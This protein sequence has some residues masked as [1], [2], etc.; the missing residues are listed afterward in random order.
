MNFRTLILMGGAGIALHGCT[1]L[2]SFS[3]NSAENFASP[4][5]MIV[6][7]NMN[8]ANGRAKE[9]VYYWGA[10]Q[11]NKEVQSLYPRKHLNSYC[12]TKGG[13][14]SLL[15][16]SSMNLVKNQWDKKQL[17]SYSSVKQG[18]GAYKCMQSDGQSWIVSIEPVTERKLDD[19]S[20]ARMVA[21]QTK[22][23]TALDAQRF[24]SSANSSN[25]SAVKKTTVNNQ[26]AKNTTS[27][28]VTQK[29]VE[30]KKEV[31]TKK[32]TKSTPELPVKQSIQV[33]ETPQQQQ[34]KY[35]VAARR[36]LNKGT[37]QVTACNNAQRA[38]SYG[39]LQ[40]TEGTKVYT[41]SGML[42]ARCLTS[43]PSY[44]SRFSNSNGQAVKILQNLAN[45]YNHAGA[46][47]MLRQ[48][49]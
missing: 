23:M 43:V 12:S 26:A 30:L 29:E 10:K 47:N 21:L 24:Y 38:Y 33:A 16:K 49:K 7:K 22:I 44:S 9:Y 28:A 13:K 20:E 34:L 8:A 41:E 25:N 27:K 11:S 14:F 4:Q 35:Y 39:K 15:Y 2:N 1:S 17:S 45:N 40:G 37:N 31:E 19:G 18:I 5:E 3:S 46:K 48:V 42:V 32:E 6:Q 36:D